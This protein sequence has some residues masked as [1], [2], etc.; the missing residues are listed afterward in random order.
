[1]RT[2]FDRFAQT[3]ITEMRA[4]LPD[5]EISRMDIVKLNDIVLHGVTARHAD[6]SSAPTLYLDTAFESRESAE[7]TAKGFVNAILSAPEAPM[8][9]EDAGSLRFD[10]IRDMLTARLIDTEL[11]HRFLQEHPFREIG[12]GLALIA[13]VDLGNGY[14]C[15][16]TDSLAEQYDM[17]EVFDTALRNMQSRH[18][19]K[20]LSLAGALTGESGNAL[21][22]EAEA[23]PM[24]ILTSDGAECFGAVAIAYDDMPKRIWEVFGKDSDYYILPSSLHELIIVQDTDSINLEELREMVITA[25]RTVVDPADRLSDS[26]FKYTGADG[27]HRVA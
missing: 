5:Y 9:A 1:M 22:G 6:S 13:E 18:P 17:D 26:V 27:L 8:T 2:T 7:D 25:N 20:M 10:K 12:A 15:V 16:I 3:V 21:E 19:A 24:S 23:D 4:M 14:R 11:N